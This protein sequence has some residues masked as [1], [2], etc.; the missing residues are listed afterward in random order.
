MA[1]AKRSVAPMDGK[2]TRAQLFP[3]RNGT[4]IRD[5]P[6]HHLV[7]LRSRHRNRSRVALAEPRPRARGTDS[8][9][10]ETFGWREHDHR[11]PSHPAGSSSSRFHSHRSQRTDRF[12]SSRATRGA[13][14]AAARSSETCLPVPKNISSGVWPAVSQLR[15]DFHVRTSVTSPRCSASPRWGIFRTEYRRRIHLSVP[16]NPSG[17]TET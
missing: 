16:K 13:F 4:F 7:D 8:L 6:P 5:C 1:G 9:F 14:F 3:N 12:S 10:P 2:A 15:R 11:L 17:R